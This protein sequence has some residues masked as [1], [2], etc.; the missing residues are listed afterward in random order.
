MV[1]QIKSIAKLVAICFIII[2]SFRVAEYFMPP[3]SIKVLV[4]IEDYNKKH[5][6]TEYK[7]KE[8]SND[9]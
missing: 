6:C 4:C 9:K 2:A 7:S 5:D 8:Q 3:P 1:E